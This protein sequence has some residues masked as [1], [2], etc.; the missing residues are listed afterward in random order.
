MPCVRSPIRSLPGGMRD[1]VARLY[2][3][4]AFADALVRTSCVPEAPKSVHWHPEGITAVRHFTIEPC[5]ALPTRVLKGKPASA[6]KQ[7][8]PEA[9][10]PFQMPSEPEGHYYSYATTYTEEPITEEVV[11]DSDDDYENIDLIDELMS[12]PYFPE[13]ISPDHT[14]SHYY[15]TYLEPTIDKILQGDFKSILDTDEEDDEDYI[16]D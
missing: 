7:A 5:A 6:I 15:Q 11:T 3:R 12:D 2:P 8:D 10:L 16:Y 14:C 1:P 4:S 9:A 13:Y